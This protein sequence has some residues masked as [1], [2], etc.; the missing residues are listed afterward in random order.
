MI[1]NNFIHFY[2]KSKKS[3]YA[4]SRDTGIPYT[5]VN[6]LA[7]GTLNINQCAYDAVARLAAYFGCHPEDLVNPTQLMRNV[8]GKYEGMA[9]DWVV[10][11]DVAELHVNDG[12]KDIILESSLSLTQPR[13]YAG[14][15]AMT[16]CLIDI[17]KEQ[18]RADEMLCENIC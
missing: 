13:F 10:R 1:N 12:G 16:K 9:Y 4:I 7:H 15:I 2:Q 17:Y 18:K 14:Y 8:S 6:R 3:L 5:T 11:D